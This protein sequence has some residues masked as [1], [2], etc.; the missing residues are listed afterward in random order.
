MKLTLTDALKNPILTNLKTANIAYQNIYKGDSEARQPVHTVYGGANLF[1]HDTAARFSTAALKNLTTYA[2]NFA[3]LAKI[4]GLIGHNL[5]P[6]EAD[7]I[8]ELTQKLEAMTEAE[9]REHPAWLAYTVYNRV[10]QKL[11]SEA[12]EDFR[13]D[14]EDGLATDPMK[15]RMRWLFKPLWK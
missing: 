4:I 1:A 11:K 15:R 9:R 10:V 7:A 14:F 3:V 13:I 2:P 8:Q 12:L 6:N 5:L